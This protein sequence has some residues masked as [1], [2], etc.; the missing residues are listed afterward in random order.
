MTRN[1]DIDT[2]LRSMDPAT[3]APPAH[4]HRAHA[5]LE[6]ILSRTPSS[7][8]PA[9]IRAQRNSSTQVRQT[10]QVVRRRR[11]VALGGLAAAA[12]IGLLVIPALTG[13]DPAFATWT[14]APVTLNG[15]DRDDAV[16]DCVASNKSTGDGMYTEDLAHAEVVIAERRG[17]WT[18]VILT[19][20]GG[21]EATCTTD[22][23]AP[24]F[25]K[26]MI[27]SIGKL[28][29]ETDPA[30]RALKPTQLGVGMITNEP[31]SM[32]AGRAG[33]EVTGITYTSITGEEVVATV[34]KGQFAFW[35]P[36]DELQDAS[37]GGSTVQVTYSDGTTDTQELSF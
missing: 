27:G 5:D 11:A 23:S 12:T 8:T 33:E 32:A 9:P 29:A 16:A 30:P 1:K 22:A 7:A 14:A 4:P 10:K 36:G 13:G 37:D 34:S 2:L 26:G 19:G 35:L 24:W 6:R 3:Q 18:T 17:A 20:A 21:F 15:A 28:G 25:D 31:L